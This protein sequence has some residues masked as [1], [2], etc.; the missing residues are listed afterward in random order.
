MGEIETIIQDLA[1]S[2]KFFNVMTGISEIKISKESCSFSPEQEARIALEWAKLI[3]LG[4]VRYSTPLV[5]AHVHSITFNGGKLNIPVYSTDFMHYR[6]TLD[7][8]NTRV[9]AVGVSGLTRLLC[10]SGIFYLFGERNGKNLNTGGLL[11]NVPGGFMEPD[12]LTNPDPIK[13]TYLSELVEEVGIPFSEEIK[14]KPLYVAQLRTDSR[15]GGRNYQD[16]CIEFSADIHG[17][18]P[19]QTQRYF[20][21]K[22]KE[23]E[24]SRL[25]LINS[26]DLPKFVKENLDRFTLRTRHT[27][28]MELASYIHG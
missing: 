10:D 7:D 17:I 2:H 12:N 9:W 3:N 18:T 27:L 22:F 15:P 28:Q 25:H 21:E 4:K 26:E 23:R 1:A 5:A 24:H 13:S 16:L 14:L 11:E 19:E 6:A 20:M 8:N